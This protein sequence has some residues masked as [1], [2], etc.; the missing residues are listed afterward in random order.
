MNHEANLQSRRNL[1]DSWCHTNGRFRRII[2]VRC[3]ACSGRWTPCMLSGGRRWRWGNG[4]DWKSG[5]P[6]SA[7]WPSLQKNTSRHVSIYCIKMEIYC[8]LRTVVLPKARS[9]CSQSA[10]IAVFPPFLGLSR[11]KQDPSIE[12]TVL[13]FSSAP[14]QPGLIEALQSISLNTFSACMANFDNIVT[15]GASPPSC[16]REQRTYVLSNSISRRSLQK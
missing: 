3:V 12:G 11:S 13:K 5:P 2:T 8:P 15:C 1:S 9:V 16:S 10:F 7:T 14:R 6:S 4:G